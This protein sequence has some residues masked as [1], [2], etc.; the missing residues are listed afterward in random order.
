MQLKMTF[1]YIYGCDI[2][3]LNNVFA[4]KTGRCRDIRLNFLAEPNGKPV[5]LQLMF[6]IQI[7]VT[8]PKYKI[9]KK[10]RDKG[11]LCCDLWGNILPDFAPAGRICVHGRLFEGEIAVEG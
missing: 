5:T 1:S 11:P 4:N 8:F 9:T 2:E 6:L 7:G 10:I 3:F